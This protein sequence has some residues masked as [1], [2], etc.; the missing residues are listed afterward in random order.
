M[1]LGPA[2]DTEP[3]EKNLA[4]FLALNL[5]RSKGLSP[6]ARG[7]QRS[8]PTLKERLGK[9]IIRRRHAQLEESPQRVKMI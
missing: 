5:K 9:N 1:G 7:P 8:P 2:V 3:K 6:A 4:S